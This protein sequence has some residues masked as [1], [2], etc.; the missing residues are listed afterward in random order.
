M[1]KIIE[2]GRGDLSTFGAPCSHMRLLR[3]HLR[4]LSES[5]RGHIDSTKGHPEYPKSF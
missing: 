1:L 5:L 2:E 3:V 4:F